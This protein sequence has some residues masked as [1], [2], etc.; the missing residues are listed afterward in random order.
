MKDDLGRQK[1]TSGFPEDRV[2]GTAV[3]GAETTFFGDVESGSL[4]V[5]RQLLLHCL[6]KEM[7]FIQW[8]PYTVPAARSEESRRC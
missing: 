4:G 5:S 3:A 2:L 6:P 7:A 8:Q 1:R